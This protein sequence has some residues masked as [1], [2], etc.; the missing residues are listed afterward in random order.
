MV[1]AGAGG[2]GVS[3]DAGASVSVG[4]GVSVKV[5][6][7]AAL[8]SVDVRASAGIELESSPQPKA[9]INGAS[10]K[11]NRRFSE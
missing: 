9:S 5:G 3:T 7:P 10:V 1:A 6:L 4:S 11:T 8:W 2:T